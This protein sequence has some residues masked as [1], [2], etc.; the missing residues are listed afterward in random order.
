MRGEKIERM[1]YST[2]QA[3]AGRAE[4]TCFKRAEVMK[5]KILLADDNN[6]F[7]MYAGILIRRMG[8]KVI[9]AK[10]G[11][12]LLNLIKLSAPDVVMLDVQLSK[13][14]GITVLSLMKEDEDISDI[15]VIMVSNDPRSETIEK[16]RSLG[17]SAYLLKPVKI[18]ELY[19]A[20]ERSVFPPASKNRRHLR[21]SFVN[22]VVLTFNKRQYELYG[23]TL[24]QGGI[25]IRG[26]DL[27]PVG[28]EVYVTLPLKAKGSMRLKGVVIYTKGLFGDEF[29]VPPGMAIE[30]RGLTDDEARTLEDYVENLIAED[31]LDSQE[32][33]VI[34]R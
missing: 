19:G 11:A 2:R 31:I 25:Y 33:P 4:T 7:L 28:S 15:P 8:F 29:K 13:M 27:F 26:M 1:I 3:L 22:K 20:L 5:N 30:F 16:C 17:C 14:D 32:E 21:A 18:E 24:S 10:G 34:R 12:D 6:I 9:P 23:E